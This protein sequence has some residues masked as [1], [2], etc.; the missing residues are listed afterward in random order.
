MVRGM[1]CRRERAGEVRGL[2]SQAVAPSR[3]VE[4]LVCGLRVGRATRGCTKQDCPKKG[5]EE[6]VRG[7][8]SEGSFT[9][10]PSSENRSV[11]HGVCGKPCRCCESLHTQEV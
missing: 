7:L 2:R 10:A 6:A 1:R 4:T 3:A 5:S 9:R 8:R 11:V